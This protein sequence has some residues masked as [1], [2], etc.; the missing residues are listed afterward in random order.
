MKKVVFLGWYGNCNTGD[1]AIL[2]GI[3]KNFL[4]RKEI[5][6][7]V[8]SS[9]PT[10]VKREHGIAAIYYSF[11]YLNPFKLF[12][13]IRGANLFVLGG[14]GILFDI[15][16][17]SI[18]F[19]I[20]G[21]FIPVMIAKWMKKPTAT[22]SIGIGPIHSKL[23]ELITK[24][25][26]NNIDIITVRDTGSK[27]ILT[28]LGVRKEIHIQPDPALFLTPEDPTLIYKT[29]KL[30]LNSK[31]KLVVIC[32]ATLHML[33]YHE[34]KSALKVISEISDYLIA[35]CNAEVLFI[36]MQLSPNNKINDDRSRINEILDTMIN[37]DKA[38]FIRNQYRPQNIL[39][40]IKR[41]D[42]VIG[43]RLH[44]IIFATVAKSP[45]IGLIYDPKV[46]FFLETTGQE[47]YSLDIRNL[48]YENLY[49]LVNN[50]LSKND[51]FKTEFNFKTSTSKE[52]DKLIND[53]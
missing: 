1:E 52:L 31:K 44:S 4:D 50:V 36:P 14:G 18:P 51:Y 29:E 35:E 53:I 38:K 15:S 25:L 48:S 23:G 47:N 5:E 11:P 3:I 6:I 40:V 21:Y 10:K 46:K 43:M 8:L 7:I 19:N 24:E 27:N 33:K 37:K 42:L 45:V 30:E 20:I 22:Y 17:K 41:A 2:E 9:S 32:P 34:R 13:V 49:F 39:G 28:D 26:F 16:D 12:K